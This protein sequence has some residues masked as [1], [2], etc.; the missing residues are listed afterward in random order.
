MLP[1]ELSA[2]I[3]SLKEGQ[4]RAALACHLV[5]DADGTL[6]KLAIHARQD[7]CRRKHCL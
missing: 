4:V 5:V 7:L 6:K 2:D 3:C 1:D